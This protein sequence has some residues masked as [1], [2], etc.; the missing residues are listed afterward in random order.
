M[1]YVQLAAPVRLQTQTPTE[2]V[3]A[4]AT[5]KA[6]LTEILITSRSENP[7]DVIFLDG[8]TERMRFSIYP[9][10]IINK[11]FDSAARPIIPLD[12]ITAATAINAKLD[13]AGDVRITAWYRYADSSADDAQ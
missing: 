5:K 11:E 6:M 3:P 9:G 2:V 4:H 13:D 7:V 8:T 1:S 12:Q 10:Q